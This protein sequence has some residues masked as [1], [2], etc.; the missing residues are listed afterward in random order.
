[1]LWRKLLALPVFLAVIGSTVKA[2]AIPAEVF[3][4]YLNEIGN[5]LPPGWVMRLP[6]RILLGGPADEEFISQLIVR[7]FPS[8]TPP[9]LTVSLFSCTSG[10]YPCLVGSFSVDS[11]TSANAQ[12]EFRKH[13]AAA[14]AVT[15]ARGIQGYLLEGQKQNPPNMFSSVMWQQDGMI[16]TVSFLTEERQNILFMAYSMAN[17]A[18]LR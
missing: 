1:M 18:P 13:L 8:T 4:P 15:L 2:S 9:G 11:Q 12:R 3:T 16:Y 10:G 6:S 5:S 14:Q 7:V 17:Q